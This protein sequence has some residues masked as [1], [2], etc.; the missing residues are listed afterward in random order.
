MKRAVMLGAAMSA[1][2]AACAPAPDAIAPVAMPAGAYDGL[3]CDAAVTL[4]ADATARLEAL[5]AQQRSAMASDAIGVLLIAVPMG[6][7]TGGDKS[8]LIAAAKGEAMSLDARLAACA[9]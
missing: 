9:G 7:L 5:A 8:G 6:S 2:L 1:A 3:S 4:R